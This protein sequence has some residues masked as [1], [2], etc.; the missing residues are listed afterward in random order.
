MK[1]Y[2][3]KKQEVAVSAESGSAPEESKESNEVSEAEKQKIV[4]KV[5][6]LIN[7]LTAKKAAPRAGGF[8]N[9]RK[10]H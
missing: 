8:Q 7:S 9:F 5:D 6:T 4:A 3:A 10:T 2:L 1:S